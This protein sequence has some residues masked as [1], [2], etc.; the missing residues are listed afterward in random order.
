MP[1]IVKSVL[2]EGI[3]LR[4]DI[5]PM[6]ISVENKYLSRQYQIRPL[7]SWW[8]KG[9]ILRVNKITGMPSEE[10]KKV[11]EQ[12]VV[13]KHV[14]LYLVPALLMP[15]DYLYFDSDSWAI[16]RD[17]GVFPGE[18]ELEVKL[19]ELISEQEGKTIKLYPYRDVF[20]G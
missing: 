3:A 8:V 16:L 13:G 6:Y 14:R 17:A 5:T 1:L 9:E 2:R 19:H 20:A 10:E 4:A 12:Y 18:Y 15:Y 7:T 11:F